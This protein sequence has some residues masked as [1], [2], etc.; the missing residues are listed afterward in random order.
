MMR[1]IQGNTVTFILAGGRGERLDPLTRGRAKPAVPFGDGRIIDFTL[2]NCLRSKLTHPY[3]L[4]QYQAGSL[5]QHVGRWWRLHA[6]EAGWD[7]AAV[8]VSPCNGASYRG[9]GDALRQNI[10]RI[11]DAD[12]VVVLS[13]DHVYDMDY[14]E[15][16]RFHVQNGAAATIG[17]IVYPKSFA[18]Q[19]GVM[20]VDSCWRIRN[21]HEK[22]SVP[23]TLP[24][25]TDEIL[26]SM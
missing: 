8:C 24:S 23:V 26:A 19:F 6:A 12:Y 18:S 1:N 22:P 4:T 7:T 14:R 21:F 20:E 15:M 11:G 13:A 25:R 3:I 17:S 10:N 9:T 2:S 16:I 5:Q